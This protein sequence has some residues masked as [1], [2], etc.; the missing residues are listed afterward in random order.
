MPLGLNIEELSNFFED[1]YIATF[2]KRQKS[3]EHFALELMNH[4]IPRL[5]AQRKAMYYVRQESTAHALLVTIQ[6]NNA[7]IESQLKDKGLL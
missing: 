4:G 6:A 1:E 7:R 3:Q 2:D 5:E